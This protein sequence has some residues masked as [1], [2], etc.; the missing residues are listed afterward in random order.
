[1]E[2]LN[3]YIKIKCFVLVRVIKNYLE[4]VFEESS[5]SYV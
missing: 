3:V 4:I 1:M 2:K 5:F